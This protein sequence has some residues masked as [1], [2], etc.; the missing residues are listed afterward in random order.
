MSSIEELLKEL[1]EVENINKEI[2]EEMSRGKFERPLLD[3]E[4]I[5]QQ[6]KENGYNL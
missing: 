3:K 4:S 2:E 6:L 1:E 5:L